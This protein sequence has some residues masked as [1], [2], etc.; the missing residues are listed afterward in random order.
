MKFPMSLTVDDMIELGP[1]FVYFYQ[2]RCVDLG[3]FI[4]VYQL[5]KLSLTIKR[6]IYKIRNIIKLF[7]KVQKESLCNSSVHLQR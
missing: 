7:N 3:E 2:K 4:E 5:A 6:R 1:V